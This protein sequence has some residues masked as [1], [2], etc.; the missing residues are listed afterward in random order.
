MEAQT[1]PRENPAPD[2]ELQR[3]LRLLI[4]RHAE[5]SRRLESI[6]SELEGSAALQTARAS[7]SGPSGQFA[8]HTLT[9]LNQRIA[10][11]EAQLDDVTGQSA[12]NSDSIQQILNSRIWKAFTALGAI[13]LRLSG[14]R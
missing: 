4:E 7:D 1:N 13:L 5:F 9:Y 10:R 3:E 2:G 14:R 6:L 11:M 12:A 8:A